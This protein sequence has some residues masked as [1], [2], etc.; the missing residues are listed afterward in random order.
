MKNLIL[1]LLI[2]GIIG[3]GDS[4]PENLTEQ[5]FTDV[6]IEHIKKENPVLKIKKKGHL[7]FLLIGKDDYE[8]SVFLDNAYKE[9]KLDT[10]DL[11]GII[12]K[13][14]K[15]SLE[16]MKTHGDDSVDLERIVPVIKDSAYPAE[17]KQSLKEAGYDTSKMDHYYEEL[18]DSLLVLY[19][20]DTVNN[21]RYL[22]KDDI[23]KLELEPNK[24]REKAIKNLDKILP[25]IKKRGSEGV[26]MVTADGTYEASLL[27]FD[28][29]WTSE[30]FKVNG[31]FVIAVPSRDLLLVTGSKDSEGISKI[32]SIAADAIKEASYYLTSELFIRKGDKWEPFINKK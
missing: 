17:V 20:V 26:Y 2:L 3:C 32:S 10:G 29:I 16:T 1:T 31:D 12:D 19:A 22:N 21:I 24:L 27:L 5:E 30:N 7:E 28:N 18:N 25:E 8:Q 15:A 23:E 6:F 14:S 9:Y 4:T 13:F 11:D